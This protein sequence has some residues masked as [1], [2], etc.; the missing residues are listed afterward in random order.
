VKPRLLDLFCGAGGC[1]V[2]YARAGFEVVGVDIGH[3]PRYPF[4]FYCADAMH[5]PLDGFDWVHASPPCQRYS[6][7]KV[8]HGNPERHPDLIADL[9]KRLLD[10]GKPF[11][12]ENVPD[13]PLLNPLMLCGTMF[14]GLKVYRHRMF[15]FGL[16]KKNPVAP[17]ECNHTHRMGKSKGEYHTLEKS[18]FITCV[19]HNFQAKSGRIAMQIDWMTRQ[20][21]SQAIP[22]AYTE[23]IGRA[24]LR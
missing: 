12:I 24:V 8:I 21:M 18:P 22:P 23:Y 15:E 5:F 10:N 19:G 4:E 9:R 2:G 6:R 14:D 17:R 11:I 16:T 1:S 20:E 13:A 3:Q 7:T